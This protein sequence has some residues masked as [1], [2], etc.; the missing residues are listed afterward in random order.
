MSRAGPRAREAIITGLP[1]R[2]AALEV[3]RDLGHRLPKKGVVVMVKG[4][5]SLYRSFQRFRRMTE[6]QRGN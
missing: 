2:N 1:G 4:Y 5:W 3:L 6:R